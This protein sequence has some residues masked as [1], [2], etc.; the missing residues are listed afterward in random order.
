MSRA[1]KDYKNRMD[2]QVDRLGI[3]EEIQLLPG[4]RAGKSSGILGRIKHGT[5]F[6][7]GRMGESRFFS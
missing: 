3:G 5:W 4:R 2:K 1:S 6:Q 7:A